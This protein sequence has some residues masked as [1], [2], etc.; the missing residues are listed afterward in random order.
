MIDQ[1][2]L[3]GL[4]LLLTLLIWQTP[5]NAATGDNVALTT[6]GGTAEMPS[7]WT[8]AWPASNCINGVT[9]S[10]NNG[11]LCHNGRRPD[12][13]EWLDITLASEVTIDRVVIYNRTNCC[14]NRIVNIFVLVSKT[15][16]PPGTD[17]ASLATAR[18]QADFEF[19]IANDVPVT[20]IDVADQ[21]G[22][23]VRLQKSGVGNVSRFINLLEVQVFEGGSTA[24]LV[25]SKEVS[26]LSPAIGDV[27]TFTLEVNNNGPAVANNVEILDSLPA[28]FTNI[29]NISHGGQINIDGDIEWNVP[30][31]A[32]GGSVTVTFDVT[33]SN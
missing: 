3:I 26:N 14:S 17:A 1:I 18:A 22:R 15:P 33:V 7:L 23:Y 4:A 19:Q 21:P 31:I 25:I 12:L 32:V 16:F 24:D 29:Q 30:N 13:N 5:S 11:A 28:G 20:T 27:V 2:S 10:N 8:P 6:N 9:A